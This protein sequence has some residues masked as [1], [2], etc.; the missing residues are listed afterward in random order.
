MLRRPVVSGHVMD[1]WM[2]RRRSVARRLK[3]LDVYGKGLEM[4]SRPNMLLSSTSVAQPGST[5]FSAGIS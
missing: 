3:G 4:L 1:R 2:K 5:G